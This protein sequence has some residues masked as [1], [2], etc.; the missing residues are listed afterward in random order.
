MYNRLEHLIENVKA[1]FGLLIS[2]SLGM[3]LFILFFQPFSIN[4]FDFNNSL[5]FVGGLGLIVLLVTYLVRIIIPCIIRKNNDNEIRKH[6]LPQV[7]YGIVIF[8]VTTLS[9]I[10]YIRYVGKVNITFFITIRVIIICIVPSVI[11]GLYDFINELK[12]E[13]ELLQVEKKNIQKQV[14]KYEDELLSK[15]I[16]FISETVS[17]NTSLL[18]SDVVYIKSADNYVEIVYREGDLFRKKLIRNTLRNIEL[19]LKSYS[20]FIRC[21]RIC[22]V[23]MYYIDKLIRNNNSHFLTIKG[24]DEKLPV[25]RQYLLRLKETV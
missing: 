21:H 23:N 11:I 15:T 3:F 25:S 14:L 16:E 9:F 20:N 10:F 13:N 7:F 12:N 4:N 17:E 5:L 1:G 22:I 2:I 18:I 6:L 24:Y 8:I 19:Q